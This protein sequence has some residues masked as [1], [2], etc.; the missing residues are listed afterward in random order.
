L[1]APR[2]TIL[3]RAASRGQAADTLVGSI[4]RQSSTAKGDRSMATF[5]STTGLRTFI[6]DVEALLD[7]EAEPHVIAQSVRARLPRLLADPSFLAPEYRESSPEH[8]RSHL[9]AVA[10]SARFSVVSLVWLPGQVTPIHDHIAW[11][12]VGVLEGSEREERFELRAAGDEHWLL[13]EREEVV[14]PGHTCC[15]VPPDENIHRVRNAGDDL[16]ISIHVYGADIAKYGSSIN[17]CFDTLPVRPGDHSGMLVA[18]RRLRG[19]GAPGTTPC[20]Q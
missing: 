16:A 7:R 2:E 14:T 17:E 9:L 1:G 8:Y 12:V 11:C 19:D 6:E 3:G 5:L 4:Q 13:P 10:P 18:W 20:D 15:L